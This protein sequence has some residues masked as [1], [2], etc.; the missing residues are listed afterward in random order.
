[1]ASPSSLAVS[2]N[3]PDTGPRARTRKRADAVRWACEEEDDVI[4]EPKD[5]LDAA[6][7]LVGAVSGPEDATLDWSQIDWRSVEENVRRLRQ[8]IFTASKAGDLARVRRLQRLMLSR[9]RAR[10]R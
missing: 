5:K 1:V 8:R 10:A 7:A 6:T 4:P 9:A 2:D 3:W